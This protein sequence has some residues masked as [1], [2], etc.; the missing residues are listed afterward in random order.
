MRKL[1][2]LALVLVFPLYLFPQQPVTGYLIDAVTRKPVEGA[3]IQKD[4][5]PVAASDQAG[6][7][8]IDAVF[9]LMLKISHLNYFPKEIIISKIPVDSLIIRLIPRNRNLDEVVVTGKPYFQFFK[10][11]SF[12][13]HQYA[14][15]DNRVWALGFA[16]KNILKPELRL[17]N[18]SGKTLSKISVETKSEIFQ[19]PSGTVHLYNSDSI[20][21]LYADQGRIVYLYPYPLDGSEEILFNLQV[22]RGETVIFRSF[23]PYRTCCEFILADIRTGF[24]DTVFQSYN[25]LQ[26]K[27]ATAAQNYSPG[28]IPDV[29]KSGSPVKQN[30]KGL[31]GQLKKDNPEY[32]GMSD[33]D[34]MQAEGFKVVHKSG[35]A[36]LQATLAS[37]A[38]FANYGYRRTIQN[39]P[40]RAWMYLCRDHYNI[41]E[42]NN[43]MMWRLSHDFN[44][45]NSTEIRL[46]P[47]AKNI[48]LVQDPVDQLLY[49]TYLINGTGFVSQLDPE[50]DLI[51]RTK[52]IN[53]FPFAENIR[54]YGGRIYFIHQSPTGQN[55]TNLYSVAA[56]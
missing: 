4:K 47:D 44:P 7:F 49:L 41:F 28:A 34:I 40:I 1:T 51:T 3:N 2:F 19:D 53:G 12:Y 31:P 13:I 55:F 37:R 48:S 33:K 16:G 32:V 23:S 39:A 21:Q 29:A 18:L 26:Y 15:Q 50:S 10:P 27:S 14:I 17:L 20:F 9:P 54:V 30:Y 38:A 22:I 42:A 5:K 8:Q 43:L 56:E 6:R 36:G 45:E 11:Q 35:D 46:N 25:R 52:Q 24:R